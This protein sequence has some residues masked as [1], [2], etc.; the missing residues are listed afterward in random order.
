MDELAKNLGLRD[1]DQFMLHTGAIPT[2]SIGWL[3]DMI[4]RFGYRL[5]IIDTLQRFYELKDAND[6]AE[7][8]RRMAPMDNLVKELGLHVIY[9]HHAGK[10]GEYLGSVGLKGMCPTYLQIKRVGEQER[11][12]VLSSDQRSG[13]NFE[14]VAISF[15]KHG[16]LKVIGT[17][18]DVYIEDAKPKIREV[19]GL[20]DS[21][22]LTEQQ[23]R[24]AI[25]GRGIVASKALRQLFDTNEV[26]RS[27]AGKKHDPFRYTMVSLFKK[28]SDNSSENCPPKEGGILKGGID[29]PSYSYPIGKLGVGRK[30]AKNAGL[31]SENNGQIVEKICAN[32]SPNENGTRTGLERDKHGTRMGQARDK[33]GTRKARPDGPG[34]ESTGSKF[35]ALADDI[36]TQTPPW[37]G[38]GNG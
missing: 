34:L 29:S 24:E 30:Q 3:R 14:S 11:Q 4:T 16:W 22:G 19:L 31:E 28:P 1:S 38:E 2:D 26:Q 6:Y 8:T 7:A 36:L 12:R 13:R 5:I 33:N 20:D 32:A 21:G 37:E 10:T 35:R 27:G 23:I 15:D 9:P 17:L 18:E 25:G